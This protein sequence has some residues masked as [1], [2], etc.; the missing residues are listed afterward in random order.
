VNI[1]P[2]ADASPFFET[3]R[4]H[5][6]VGFL[7]DPNPAGGNRDGVGWN[8]S[9]ATVN[10]YSSAFGYYDKDYAGWQPIRRRRKTKA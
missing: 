10:T 2:S 3:V 5:T 1:P 7:I 9:A 4:V 8:L 6:I